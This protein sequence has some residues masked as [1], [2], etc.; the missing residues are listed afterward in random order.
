MKREKMTKAEIKEAKEMI[1]FWHNFEC[2]PFVT[3]YFNLL[4]QTL[5]TAAGLGRSDVRIYLRREC[6]RLGIE[7]KK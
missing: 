5:A 7:V 4:E 3:R 2:F 6:K 1:A